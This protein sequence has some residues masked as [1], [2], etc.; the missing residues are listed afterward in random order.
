MIKQEDEQGFRRRNVGACK[1]TKEILILRFSLNS[2]EKP[3]F[4]TGYW[5]RGHIVIPDRSD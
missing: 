5:K 1:G 3:D 2:E 4:W